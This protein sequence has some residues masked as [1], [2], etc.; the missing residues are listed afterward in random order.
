MSSFAAR[1]ASGALCSPAVSAVPWPHE[2]S[3]EPL[4]RHAHGHAAPRLPGRRPTRAS[5]A[6]TVRAASINRSGASG[7]RYHPQGRTRN[8]ATLRSSRDQSRRSQCRRPAA[9]PP[10]PSL[11]PRLRLR[12][13]TARSGATCI[14]P[15]QCGVP[16]D[17]SSSGRH[18]ARRGRQA[19]VSGPRRA[20]AARPS[21]RRSS[22]P[23][24]PAP[25]H[26]AVSV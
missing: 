11:R 18:P 17:V 1:R 9:R 20:R 2:P 14:E 7:A 6:R 8:A 5:P 3:L 24:S 26:R 13:L 25:R 10:L 22:T 12:R 21:S 19:T 4:T 16:V 23:T 15:T